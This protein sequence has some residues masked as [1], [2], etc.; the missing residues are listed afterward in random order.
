MG[1]LAQFSDIA[2]L[3]SV[4]GF[5]LFNHWDNYNLSN[6]GGKYLSLSMIKLS[7]IIVLASCELRIY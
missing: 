1:I 6:L 4:A 5:S 7:E 2:L 3:E